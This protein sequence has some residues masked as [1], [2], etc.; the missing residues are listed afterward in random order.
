M[1]NDHQTQSDLGVINGIRADFRGFMGAY[2]LIE[3]D[4]IAYG[5]GK[6]VRTYDT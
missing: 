1:S 3:K 2:E 6:W 4:T 5:S